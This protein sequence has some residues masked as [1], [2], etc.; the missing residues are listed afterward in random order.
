MSAEIV[1]LNKVR[2]A[3]QRAEARKLADENRVI[4]GRSK[5]EKTI[6]AQSKARSD[7]ELDGA[8]RQPPARLDDNHDDLDPGNVS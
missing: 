3:R 2:K 4:H 1:N 6:T 8:Q 5:A 7:A